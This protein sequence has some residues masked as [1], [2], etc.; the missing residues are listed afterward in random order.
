MIDFLELEDREEEG[1]YVSILFRNQTQESYVF[2]FDYTK[3]NI[4]ILVD[5]LKKDGVFNIIDVTGQVITFDD[6]KI[7][8]LR[9]R[10]I[11][12][13]EMRDYINRVRESLRNKR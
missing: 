3:S 4:N 6:I 7:D 12:N 9:Y 5:T 8:R 10:K 13:N 2:R 11:T 1:T